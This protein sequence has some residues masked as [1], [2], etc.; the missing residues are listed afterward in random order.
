MDT[1]RSFSPNGTWAGRSAVSAERTAPAG[2]HG[3]ALPLTPRE[4]ECLRLLADGLTTRG[5]A[6]TLGIAYAT[7]R[8]HLASARDKLGVRSTAAALVLCERRGAGDWSRSDAMELHAAIEQGEALVSLADALSKC[9]SFE[10][11][12]AALHNHLAGYGVHSVSFAIVAEPPGSFTTGAYMLGMSLPDEVCRLYEAAGGVACDPFAVLVANGI[13]RQTVRTRD[14]APEHV[15]RLSPA[16]RRFH[17]VLPDCGICAVTGSVV[18]D[19]PTGAPIAMPWN[20]TDGAESDMLRW[21]ERYY[22]LNG[23]TTELFWRIGQEKRLF[24][25]TI[26]LTVRQR[27]ALQNAARGDRTHESAARMGISPRAV[28]LLLTQARKACRAP[29][30]AAAIYR[31]SVFRSLH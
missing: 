5:A 24:R 14:I 16:L 17:A 26:P 20:M 29:T 6:A 19:A 10:D 2:R 21:P 28:E 12:W 23:A 27:E 3:L 13:R 9:D 22:A 8:N 1:R 25:W 11:A 15:A 4:Q 18:R 31:A 7:M 30:T